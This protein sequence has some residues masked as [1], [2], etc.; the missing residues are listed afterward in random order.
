MAL[1]GGLVG[2]SALLGSWWPRLAFRGSGQ[3]GPQTAE[4]DRHVIFGVVLPAADLGVLRDNQY[5]Y[6]HIFHQTSKLRGQNALKTR[7]FYEQM[8]SRPPNR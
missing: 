4:C 6:I 8:D 3:G 7:M 1:K 2:A 5:P